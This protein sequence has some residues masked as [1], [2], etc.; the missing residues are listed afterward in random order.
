MNKNILITFATTLALAV[1]AHAQSGGSF[2]IASSTTDAGGGISRGGSFALSGTIGQP[3]AATA[4]VS[5]N[6]RFQL[7]PGFWSGI[8][9][10]PTPGAPLMKIRLVAAGQAVLSWPVSVTG[11]ALEACADL[12]SGVWTPVNNSVMDTTTEHTVSVSAAG[13]RCYRLKQETP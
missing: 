5:A 8:T 10:L 1:H 9:V 11:F 6:A 4:L 2:A 12:G 7:E 3:D 13:H